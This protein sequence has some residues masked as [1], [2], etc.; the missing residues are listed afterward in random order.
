MASLL[1]NYRSVW[2]WSCFNDFSKL[3][4]VNRMTSLKD[5]PSEGYSVGQEAKTSD[6]RRS[7]RYPSEVPVT[8]TT[9]IQPPLWLRVTISG[10]LRDLS[11]E[12]TRIEF[13]TPPQVHEGQPVMLAFEHPGLQYPLTILAR[14]A[15]VSGV[16][17]GVEFAR[18]YRDKRSEPPGP[19]IEW[20]RKN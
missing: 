20:P 18:I 1:V 13:S 9:Y 16:V 19:W 11:R 2:M 15:W 3:G 7:D 4:A 5:T 10:T 12:G 8:V 6:Q 17:A 14:I